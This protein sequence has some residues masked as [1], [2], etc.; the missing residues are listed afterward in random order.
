MRMPNKSIL[1]YRL[2]TNKFIFTHGVDVKST[3]V[4]TKTVE[5][6]VVYGWLLFESKQTYEVP[7]RLYCMGG[8]RKDPDIILQLSDSTIP[9]WHHIDRLPLQKELQKLFSVTKRF[10]KELED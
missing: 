1:E 5:L 4:H 8:W 10:A 3:K 2:I 7:A 6:E 9:K